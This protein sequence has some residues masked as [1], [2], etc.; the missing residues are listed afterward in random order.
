VNLPHVAARVLGTPLLI[1]PAKRDP[2]RGSRLAGG[3]VEPIHSEADPAPSASITVERIA[4]A[5]MIG[6]LVWRWG[7][8]DAPARR[9]CVTERT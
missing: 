1:A 7:Y 4:V 8:I 9:H 2:R 3:A 6:T 5:S